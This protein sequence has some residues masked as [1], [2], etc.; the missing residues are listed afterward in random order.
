MAHFSDPHLGPN[1]PHFMDLI[2]FSEGTSTSPLTYNEGYDILV[3]GIH[4]SNRFTEYSDHPF[5]DGRT[6]IVVSQHPF[7]E[8]TAA[9]RYQILY[10]YWKAYKQQ[11]RLPDFSPLSQDLVALQMITECKDPTTGKTAL[12]CII[13]GDI[14]KAIYA[15]SSRWASFPGNE[16]HQGG[17]PIQTLLMKWQ[18]LA[19]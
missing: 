19:A 11:L 12:T 9:G 13:G 5:A 6:P 10:R 7:L 14:E 1:V 15:C 17:K 2:A 4:S 18:E 16:Y 8:S 3:Q